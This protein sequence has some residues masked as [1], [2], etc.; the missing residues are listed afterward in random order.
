MFAFNVSKTENATKEKFG[1]KE[2][3]E[4]RKES[5]E[6]EREKKRGGFLLLERA[7][8]DQVGLLRWLE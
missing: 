3:L 6:G 1:A 7:N 5:E 8:C 2:N 4:A